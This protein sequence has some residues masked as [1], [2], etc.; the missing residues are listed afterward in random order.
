MAL[1]RIGVLGAGHIGGT[2]AKLFARAGH[3]VAVAN[4]R[5]PASLASFV[6]SAGPSVRA[7][8]PA[9]AVAFGE[10]ILLAIP[11]RN[12]DQLPPGKLFAEKIAIDSMNPYSAVGHVI[13]L[14]ERTSSE[15]VAKQLPGA[16][17][18]KAFNTMGWKTL[19][20][21]GGAVDQDRLTIFLAGDDVAAKTTVATL[22]E[23]IGFAPLDTGS[24][25]DGGRRQQPGSPLYG[26]PLTLREAKRI[27]G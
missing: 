21:G 17:L 4:S 20:T 6:S 9:D 3:Q 24:L 10:V 22:I 13:D 16:R 27:L 15:E 26:R 8:S 19:E 1:L 23:G 7:T 18:V 25:R 12:K 2:A 14:G 5:G 11:W